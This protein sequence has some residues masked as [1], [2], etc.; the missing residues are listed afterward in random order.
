[1]SGM[2]RE[3]VRDRTLEGHEPARKRGKTISGAGVTDPGGVYPVTGEGAGA[4]QHDGGGRRVAAGVRPLAERYQCL[5]VERPCS[6]CGGRRHPYLCRGER[7]R[8][9]PAVVLERRHPGQHP[10]TLTISTTTAAPLHGIGF[11][12]FP[13]GVPV[14][15]T[16]QTWDGAGCVD[17]AAVTGNSAVYRDGSRSPPG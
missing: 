8:R 5:G 7:D 12:S 13:D 14:D 10:D 17:Q 3:Y 2:E 9:E 6:P 4:G 16:V 1:M 15:F 11:A